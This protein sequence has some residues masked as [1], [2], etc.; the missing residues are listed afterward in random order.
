MHSSR[1][2]P[3]ARHRQM[4]VLMA[5]VS[6]LAG[7]QVAPGDIVVP[8]ANGSDG[9]FNP[10]SNIQVD[11]SL[12]PTGSWDGPNANPGRGVYDPEK[13]AVVFRYTSVNIPSGVTVTFKNHPK[14]APVV[15]LVSESVTIN[16]AIVLNGAAG[17]AAES[18]A[19]PATPGPGGF[20][21][22]TGS[23][24]QQSS[25][26]GY[27]VGGGPW[28]SGLRGRGG[29]YATSLINTCEGAPGGA[30]YGNAQVLPLIGGSGGS[31]TRS[32]N[33]RQGGGAGGGAILI[34]AARQITLGSAGQIRAIGGGGSGAG[35]ICGVD[36]SSGGGS[37][38]AIRLIAEAISGTGTLNAAGGGISDTGS[39]GGSGRIRIEGNAVSLPVSGPMFS[40]VPAGAI[41]QL[42]PAGDAP[43]VR[44]AQISGQPVPADPGAELTFPDQDVTVPSGGSAV[45]R[46]ECRNM[47]LNWIVRLRIVPLTGPD[48][49]VTAVYVEG[50]AL[51]SVWQAQASLGVGFHTMQARAVS[52]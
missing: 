16:G 30:T 4:A 14:N 13:W 52:P 17:H 18:P 36:T 11:L 50:D 43:T 38:G 2:F 48:L 47:P 9:A 42:W 35:S 22:G 40:L 21:G 23:R 39:V 32:S 19:R 28:A 3:L 26:A 7:S 27:G 44:I 29:A 12:A 46:L 45:I 51:A 31:G 34:A 37:G 20:R 8:G 10:T 5:L 15:W 25:S 24:T 49:T 41:A 6:C 1:F 33:N